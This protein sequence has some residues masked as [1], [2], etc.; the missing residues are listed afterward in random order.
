M[1]G[2]F[3]APLGHEA[4][5]IPSGAVARN[6]WQTRRGT[7]RRLPRPCEVGRRGSTGRPEWGTAIGAPHW[8]C[9]DL[10]PGAKGIGLRDVVLT[11]VSRSRNPAGSVF[12]CGQDRG[13]DQR[14]LPSDCGQQAPI[15]SEIVWHAAKRRSGALRGPS[16]CRKFQSE[17]GDR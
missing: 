14:P 10:G 16:R 7:Q 8:P 15:R 1:A 2:A 11:P 3:I 5:N 4:P 13:I 9:S 17:N 6:R 12:R